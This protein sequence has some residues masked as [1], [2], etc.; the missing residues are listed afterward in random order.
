MF[1]EEYYNFPYPLFVTSIHML[2]QWTMAA[3]TLGLMP[4]LRPTSRPRSRDYAYVGT[5]TFSAES[6]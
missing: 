2:V 4:R 6:D 1:S 3:I 5:T